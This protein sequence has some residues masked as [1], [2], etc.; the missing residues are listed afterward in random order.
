MY[1]PKFAD[2][3]IR[4]GPIPS[5][6][7]EFHWNL[8]NLWTLV[9]GRLDPFRSCSIGRKSIFKKLQ[10]NL[11]PIDMNLKFP[12]ILGAC[13]FYAICCRG[14]VVHRH[15]TPEMGP[16]MGS[17]HRESEPPTNN[18]HRYRRKREITCIQ[19]SNKAKLKWLR[20]VRLIRQG[21]QAANT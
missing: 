6:F 20:S 16:S 11:I 9:D 8:T 13:N 3:R 4:T 1:I 14:K 21:G 10:L 18:H 15:P 5:H 17:N 7:V 2:F 19:K 12:Q